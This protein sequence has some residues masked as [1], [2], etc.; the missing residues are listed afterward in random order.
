MIIIWFVMISIVDTFTG[1]KSDYNEL[2]TLC[3]RSSQ[4]FTL[5]LASLSMFSVGSDPIDSRQTIGVLLSL[6]ANMAS[7]SRTKPSAYW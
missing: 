5:F 6:S 3:I 4:L 1:L 7:R 2:L